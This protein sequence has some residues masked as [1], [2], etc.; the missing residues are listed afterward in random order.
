MFRFN[1]FSFLFVFSNFA[2]RSS[3]LQCRP[4][5]RD[6]AYLLEITEVR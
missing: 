5:Y 2:A 4:N 1:L 3:K 6:N